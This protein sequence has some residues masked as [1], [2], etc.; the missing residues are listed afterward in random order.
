MSRLDALFAQ[1]RDEAEL[2]TLADKLLQEMNSYG[3]V[4]QTYARTGDEI[5]LDKSSEIG[6]AVNDDVAALRKAIHKADGF[7]SSTGRTSETRNW[8][9]KCRMCSNCARPWPAPAPRWVSKNWLLKSP[10]KAT[11]WAPTL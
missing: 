3:F 11:N 10:V 4:A 6:G 2:M 5:L 8:P 7:R 1:Y 9:S